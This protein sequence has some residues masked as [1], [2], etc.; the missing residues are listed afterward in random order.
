VTPT[1][2]VDIQAP[3]LQGV[4]SRAAGALG[5]V[6]TAAL[7]F[8]ALMWTATAVVGLGVSESKGIALSWI[9]MFP[10]VFGF[11]ARAVRSERLASGKSAVAV[12]FLIGAGAGLFASLAL[13]V[14]FEGIWP[15]L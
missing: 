2:P 15:G 8:G 14:F 11:V 3:A 13:L 9:A 7:V 4:E 1:E 5:L 10:T 12:P 6:P